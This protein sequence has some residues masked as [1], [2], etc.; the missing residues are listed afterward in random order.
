MATLPLNDIVNIVVNVSPTAVA[1]R[2]GFNL[3]LIIGKSTIISAVT[4]VKVYAS[5]NAMTSDGWQ[6]TEPEYL[7]AQR[8]F[9]Q[10]PAPIKVAVG[11][12]D[13]TGTETAVQA[14]TA[15]RNSNTDWYA[16]M[17]C[18]VVKADILA[19]AAYIETASPASAFFYTTADVD[20]LAGTEG[21]VMETL[22]TSSYRRTIGQYST[23]TDAVASILGYAMGANTSLSNSAYTLA[24]KS[25]PGVTTETLTETQVGVIKGNNGNVYISRGSS[26]NFF[27]QGTMANGTHFDEVINLDMLSN[28]IQI[29]I[30]NILSSLPKVPQTEDGVS[31]LV[32]AISA[33]CNNYRDTGFIAPGVWNAA[34]ILSLST[35][36]MLSNGYLVLADKIAN[37]SES[38]RT[39]RK[40][41]PIYVALKLAGAIENATIN[42]LVNR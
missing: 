22:K 25:E 35:G 31:M 19:V 36:D 40:S 39:A 3:G 9:A 32:N 33:V 2:S 20:V 27:E 15:C 1:A 29:A 8:Y 18:G 38:D 23:Q 24:Y 41:P 5:L 42:V 30:M 12:W 17:I 10:D 4:R 14:V 11:R 28:S 13:G 21:N 26:Y 16:C 37:Q 6:G 34:P 7:A